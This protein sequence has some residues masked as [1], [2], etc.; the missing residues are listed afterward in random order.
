MSNDL[1]GP[2]VEADVIGVV[3]APYWF[4]HHWLIAAEA[5]VSV[6]TNGTVQVMTGLIP[7]KEISP[8]P[9]FD[10]A[11][12]RRN[13]SI[14]SRMCD[15]LLRDCDRWFRVLEH[16]TTTL[17][18]S[19]KQAAERQAVV[20]GDHEPR[21]EAHGFPHLASV[22][23][24]LLKHPL[25]VGGQSTWSVDYGAWRAAVVP[26]L[27]RA[28]CSS[29]LNPGA[30]FTAGS[31]PCRGCPIA[32]KVRCFEILGPARRRYQQEARACVIEASDRI[33]PRHYHYTGSMAA[34]GTV[35][36]GRGAEP[37]QPILTFMDRNCRKVVAK[38]I[39]D[40]RYAAASFY[41]AEYCNPGAADDRLKYLGERLRLRPIVAE[42]SN[43]KICTPPAFGYR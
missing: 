6:A 7:L 22:H 24:H 16:H 36:G 21:Y 3:K 23:H 26:L 38:H 40:G 2:F 12:V 34:V 28:G 13:W 25:A 14:Q 9:D 8:Y 35:A 27:R 10:P 29:V 41:R 17:V 32:R 37:G 18:L 43:V 15:L 11:A 20:R 30:A 1:V 39:K 31:N 33:Q 42:C 5:Q 19:L 4:N